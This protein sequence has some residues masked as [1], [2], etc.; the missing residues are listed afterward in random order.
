MN[1][2]ENLFDYFI[3]AGTLIKYQPNDV[4]YMQED[5]TNNLYLILKGRVR[6]FLISKDGQEITIDIIG[7]GRIFGESSFL[8][9]T[10]RPVCVS[11]IETVELVS[12][13]LETLYPTILESKELTLAIMRLLSSTNDYLTNQVKK[14]YLYNR[15]EKIAAFLIEQNKKTITF[16]HDEIASLTGLSRVTVTK[17][18]NDFCKVGWIEQKYKKIII[19]DLKALNN[20]LDK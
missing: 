4:I 6:V 2:S 15:H 8:Q 3:N 9:N 17:I 20:Y 18:L 7:K 13:Q 19:R 12:C 14:A 5:A 10:N 1:I 16:T 11:A